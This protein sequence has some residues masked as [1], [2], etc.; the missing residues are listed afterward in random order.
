M[1]PFIMI[2]YTEKNMKKTLSIFLSL[3]MLFSFSFGMGIEAEAAG[4]AKPTGVKASA[5]SSSN[6]KVSWKKVKSATGYYIYRAASK[7]GKYSK[8]GTVKKGSTLSYTNGSLSPSK[9]Y[10]Y[11][12]K[13]YAGKKTSAYSAVISAKTKSIDSQIKGTWR[14]TGSYLG[15]GDDKYEFYFNGS[16]KVKVT[17]YAMDY[18]TSKTV[19]YT[20]SGNK[21]TFSAFG[22]KYTV[23]TIN[24]S[25]LLSFK[26]TEGSY[27]SEGL[28]IKTSAVS[29]MDYTKAGNNFDNTKW[30]SSYFSKL[31]KANDDALECIYLYYDEY[32][33]ENYFCTDYDP[34]PEDSWGH[35]LSNTVCFIFVKYDDEYYH[36]Y[37]EKTSSKK[38]NA[39]IYQGD[40]LVKQETWTL[41]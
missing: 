7:K 20:K 1:P 13:A 33:L 10:Y 6:I 15:D 36:V 31:C 14:W 25:S 24:N 21:V 5:V 40:K 30:N 22:T 8:V 18:I 4:I 32:G 38:A 23:K 26:Q 39:F 41:I 34:Y 17:I 19:K 2:K 29:N 3:I 27:S 11:K 37:L 16:G 28:L 35:L 12:V 9:T